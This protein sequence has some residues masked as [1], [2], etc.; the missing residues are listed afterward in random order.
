MPVQTV[1]I[2]IRIDRCK[3]CLSCVRV[4]TA[5]NGVYEEGP[6]GY[7]AVA[8][9]D[10]CVQCLICHTVCPTNAIVHENYRKTMLINPDETIAQR[11]RNMI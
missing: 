8:R 3:K 10:E 4:C 1:T 6:D 5:F 7:P 2:K 11:Y 9:P